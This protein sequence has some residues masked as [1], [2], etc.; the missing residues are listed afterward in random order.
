MTGLAREGREM[1]APLSFVKMLRGDR[2]LVDVVL[3][4]LDLPTSCKCVA[5]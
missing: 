1:A 3:M 4:V 5:L 2:P